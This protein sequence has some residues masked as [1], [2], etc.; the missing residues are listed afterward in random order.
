MSLIFQ[1]VIVQIAVKKHYVEMP[2][3]S[4]TLGIF[5]TLHSLFPSGGSK[6]T[7]HTVDSRFSC[8]RTMPSMV[9]N[10]L[11]HIAEVCWS[12]LL[13]RHN[14]YLQFMPISFICPTW[15]LPYESPPCSSS[16]Y[17]TSETPNSIIEIHC[18]NNIITVIIIACRELLMSIN[19]CCIYKLSF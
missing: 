14:M 3:M 9:I 10:H 17:S 16:Y 7:A 15:Q 8:K 11:V 12:K 4:L 19:N 5:R 1:P 6:A 13:S 2:L 18:Y